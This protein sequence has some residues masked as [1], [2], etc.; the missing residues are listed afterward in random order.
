MDF[1]NKYF[2]QIKELFEGM[3]PGARITSA[4]L[5][6][7]TV[8]SLGYLFT[9]GFHPGGDVFLLDNRAFTS[10][11]LTPM[12]GAFATEGLADAEIVGGRIRV[13]RGKETAYVAALAKAG[14]LPHDFSS[15]LDNAIN[16]SGP[17]EDKAEVP[18]RLLARRSNSCWPTSFVPW[19]ASS[20]PP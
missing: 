8:A 20:G 5:L 18:G 2:A 7:V 13:P 10:D 6:V 1:L 17:F 9:S 4:L 14:V 12:L 11:E 19:T 15:I 3:T 16:K